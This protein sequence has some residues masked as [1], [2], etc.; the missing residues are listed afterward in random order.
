MVSPIP[1]G[2]I[3]KTLLIVFMFN[4]MEIHSNKLYHRFLKYPC[5]YGMKAGLPNLLRVRR[6]RDLTISM[7][8]YSWARGYACFVGKSQPRDDVECQTVF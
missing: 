6:F 2:P 4:V 1:F 7:Y 8:K 3:G 5:K